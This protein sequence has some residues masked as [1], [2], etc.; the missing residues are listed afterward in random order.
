MAAP[1]D[2]MLQKT[3]SQPRKTDTQNKW[4]LTKMV[5]HKNGISQLTVPV[6]SCRGHKVLNHPHPTLYCHPLHSPLRLLL[7]LLV[8]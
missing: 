1:I 5:S 4:H 6:T 7:L 2:T 3:L 8:F